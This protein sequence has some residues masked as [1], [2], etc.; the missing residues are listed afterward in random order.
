MAAAPTLREWIGAYSNLGVTTVSAAPTGGTD[1]VLMARIG[2]PAY[3]FIQDP[4][5][6]ESTAHHSSVD[7]FDHLR[8]DDL[9]QAAAVLASV[10]LSAANS[11]KVVP[12]NVLPGKPDDS[13]PFRY[14]DPN[15]D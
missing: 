6:Y 4:L 1:H 14:K 12:P 7:T 10:L 11:D 2:L 3:Q 8:A 13:D 5:D 9:R 15:A